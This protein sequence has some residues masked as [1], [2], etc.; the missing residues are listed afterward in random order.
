MLE[1]KNIHAGEACAILCNGPTLSDHCL[2]KIDCVT[3]GLNMSWVLHDASYHVATD[4]RQFY[5]MRKAG[6][7]PLRLFTGT[8]GPQ[9]VTSSHVTPITILE[10]D[11]WSWDLEKGAYLRGTVTYLALQLAAYMGFKTIN[12]IGLDLCR[13]DGQPK[14]KGHPDNWKREIA[15]S[16][17]NADGQIKV[18][19]Y[20]AEEL[21]GNVEVI[22]LSPISA[23]ESWPKKKF[24][25][26]FSDGRRKVEADRGRQPD[27]AHGERKQ[28]KQRSNPKRSNRANSRQKKG[29]KKKRA[30]VRVS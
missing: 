4:S 14:F 18:M 16:D 7:W 19:A 15:F 5:K 8:N 6:R 25:E 2:T 28:T 29:R 11:A 26:V 20:A 21:A 23:C 24:E 27:R 3:V 13:R 12:M 10:G 17:K 9:S 1:W 30:T 22:N